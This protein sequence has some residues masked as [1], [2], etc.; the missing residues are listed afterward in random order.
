MDFDRLKQIIDWMA[1][2]PVCELELSDGDWRVHLVKAATDEAA[3]IA[4]QAAAAS[5]VPRFTVPAASPAPA[6]DPNLSAIE[7][8]ETAQFVTAPLYGVVHFSP[9]PGSPDFVS[10]GQAVRAGQP[11]CVIEAMK[12]LNTVE[13]ERDGVVAEILAK[14]GAEVTAGQPLLRLD[15]PRGKNV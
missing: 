6:P 1:V 7:R 13:A 15:H 9:A 11:L 2:S 4:P 3:A 8:P 14:S 5:Q 10:V 12:V